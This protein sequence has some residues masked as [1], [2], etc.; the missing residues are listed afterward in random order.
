MKYT[1]EH[2]HAIG[3]RDKSGRAKDVI[4]LSAADISDKRKLGAALRKARQLGPGASIGNFRVEHRHTGNVIVAFPKGTGISSPGS[5]VLTPEGYDEFAFHDVA[6]RDVRKL[7][8]TTPSS[9]G[10]YTAH[11]LGGPKDVLSRASREAALVDAAEYVSAHWRKND[12]G[13]W[14]AK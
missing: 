5:I 6:P 14:R 7:L 10:G 9:T 2:I 11:V 3:G 4:E 13:E 12:A 8:G 1:V